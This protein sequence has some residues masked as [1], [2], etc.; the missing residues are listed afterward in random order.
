MLSVSLNKTFP[1]FLNHT[2]TSRQRERER[3]RERGRERGRERDIEGERDIERERGREREGRREG[4][5]DRWRKREGEEKTEVG[6]NIL[7]RKKVRER[8]SGEIESPIYLFLCF[9]PTSSSSPLICRFNHR[10]VSER[11][12]F[13]RIPRR[14]SKSVT[15]NC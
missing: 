8:E 11:A 9:C 7:E 3:V 13:S 2:P 10:Q 1:S 4:E 12:S 5:T 6:I 15:I 14:F